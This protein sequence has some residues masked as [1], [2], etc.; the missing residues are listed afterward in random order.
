MGHLQLDILFNTSAHDQIILIAMTPSRN[1]VTFRF[2]REHSEIFGYNFRRKQQELE[3]PE[4]IS[5]RDGVPRL[6]VCVVSHRLSSLIAGSVT[7]FCVHTCD[8]S[9]SL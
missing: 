6:K 1:S 3:S 7:I 9:W 2:L 8:A 5:S 4:T